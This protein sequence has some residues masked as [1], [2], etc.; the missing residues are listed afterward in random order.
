M[1]MVSTFNLQCYLLSIY[2]DSF[3]IVCV[4]LHKQGVQFQKVRPFPSRTRRLKLIY[5]AS[6]YDS[7]RS[8]L[9]PRV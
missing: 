4:E 5:L 2:S 6:H 8:L 1:L 9:D 7:R 3:P